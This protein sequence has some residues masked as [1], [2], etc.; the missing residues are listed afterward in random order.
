MK[1]VVVLRSGAKIDLDGVT[2]VSV[3]SDPATGEATISV[4]HGGQHTTELLW[5]SRSELAAIYKVA[6]P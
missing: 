2:D 1:V 5:A 3:G 6:G 4:T